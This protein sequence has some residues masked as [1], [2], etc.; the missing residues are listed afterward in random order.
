MIRIRKED[1]K[2]EF[3]KRV[4]DESLGIFFKDEQPVK[5]EEEDEDEEEVYDVPDVEESEDITDTV[6]PEVKPVERR[7]PIMDV[8]GEGSSVRYGTENKPSVDVEENKPSSKELDVFS[9]P[10]KQ[11]PKPA[12]VKPEPLEDKVENSVI[13]APKLVM[14]SPYTR[15]DNIHLEFF[16][17]CLADRIG[18]RI[19]LK[20]VRG[21]L[22]NFMVT[23]VGGAYSYSIFLGGKSRSGKTR[24]FDKYFA[25][26]PK[27][28]QTLGNISEK[29]IVPLAPEI[30]DKLAIYVE[31]Y[32]EVVNGNDFI[33]EVFKHIDEGRN[34]HYTAN[35]KTITIDGRTR[36]GYTGA[37]ENV[38][39][40][41]MDAE[42]LA[43]V[44]ALETR[45][46]DNKTHDICE[47]QDLKDAG[48]VSE[49]YFSEKRFQ[50]IK[51]HFASVMFDDSKCENSFA[52][53]FGKEYL[54]E[55]QKSVHY[56]TL[57][58]G[59][60][61]GFAKFD[62]PNRVRKSEKEILVNLGDIYL[63]HMSYH[64]TYCD[65]LEKITTH[66]YNSICRNPNLSDSQKQEEKRKYESDMKKIKTMKHKKVNWQELWNS[67]YE[68][69]KKRYPHL[70]DDWV[71]SQSKDGKVVVYDPILRRD[72]Y[73]CDVID[74]KKIAGNNSATANQDD[75]AKVLSE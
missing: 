44:I 22:K 17:Y 33:K 1:F 51:A 73:L 61:K 54:P 52:V 2:S 27:G 20:S 43:R 75:P 3:G 67:G 50:K 72:V 30:N 10:V 47:D 21:E 42:A 25:L 70:A 26:F 6:V 69:V 55:T 71:A 5:V 39:V 74:P 11:E 45:D 62:N 41:K 23:Y 29:G 49:S 9:E 12:D 32:Q 40:Q 19:D 15:G 48:D 57:Y 37:L 66:S 64:E 18:D 58:N 63:A 36:V 4:W 53:Y 35:G 38:K 68:R 46:D 31:E 65:M 28:K 34:W 13:L 24:L 56:R 14:S 8:F 60:I 16:S 7:D 59:L